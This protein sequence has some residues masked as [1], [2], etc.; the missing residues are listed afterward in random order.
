MPGR[1][2]H[3]L[4]VP[5][6]LLDDGVDA[7]EEPDPAPLVHEVAVVHVDR[8][9]GRGQGQQEEQEGDGHGGEAS[10]WCAGACPQLGLLVMGKQWTVIRLL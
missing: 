8:G 6:L 2:P 7:V 3:L 9:E 4:V 10:C 1:V 5:G